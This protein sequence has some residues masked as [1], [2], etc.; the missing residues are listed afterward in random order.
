MV[1]VWNRE[2]GQGTGGSRVCE[3]REFDLDVAPVGLLC[4]LS[5]NEDQGTKYGRVDIRPRDEHV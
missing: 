1:G 2:V 4:A 3:H 5:E